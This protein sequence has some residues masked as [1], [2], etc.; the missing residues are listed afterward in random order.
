M[1]HRLA[2][3][4][5]DWEK[6][7]YKKNKNKEPPLQ[8]SGEVEDHSLDEIG[9]QIS[10]FLTGDCLD[11]SVE[12]LADALT[13]GIGR[14]APEGFSRSGLYLVS[15]F[16]VLEAAEAIGIGTGFTRGDVT[17]FTLKR[18]LETLVD[19]QKGVNTMLAA[20]LKMAITN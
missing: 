3:Q 15:K 16:A 18:I 1:P 9:S 19:V 14:K 20:P 13:K 2:T 6:M 11:K 10:S 8:T 4:V 17:G 12:A 5:A 7:A